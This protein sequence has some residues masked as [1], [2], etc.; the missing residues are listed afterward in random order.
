M[1]HRDGDRQEDDGAVREHHHSGAQSSADGRVHRREG[2]L[3]HCACAPS[4]ELEQPERVG[5]GS[6]SDEAEVRKDK[7]RFPN[8]VIVI[9]HDMY[10]E[11]QNWEIMPEI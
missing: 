5:G 3:G 8:H 1:G 6:R 2:P 11:W 7:A 4:Q 9:G 10:C